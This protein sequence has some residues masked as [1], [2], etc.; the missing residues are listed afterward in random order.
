M[1][2]GIIAL[3]LMCMTAGVVAAPVPAVAPA[4][5]VTFKDWTVGC[6]NGLACQAVA[7][8]SEGLPEGALSIVAKRAEGVNGEFIIEMSGAT[9]ESDR[10]RVVIDGRIVDTGT[11][12]V[13]S[14]TIKVSG[15]D[16]VKLARA[17]AKGKALRLVD[18][19]GNMLG[20]A[21]LFGAAAAFRYADAAQGR[22][23]SRGAIIATGPKI[24]A[25]KKAT[26]PVIA[27]KKIKPTESLPDTAALVALSETSACAAERLGPTEDSAY[28]LGTGPNGAQALVLLNCG[29]AAYNFSVGVYVGQQD[30]NEKW[31]FA[32]AKFDYNNT[33]L[34]EKGDLML[35]VNA[36][37]DSASQSMSS[38]AKGRGIG[39]CGSS[40]SYVW[41]GAMFR[42]T[43][44]TSMEEC[45]GSLDWI[46]VWRADVRLT[47]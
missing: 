15:V 9:T 18:G 5:V 44:A 23:G 13:G 42:L 20:Q 8:M 17:M 7:L 47:D 21:S 40:H 2:R 6:D 41:D 26:L 43:S 32:P 14:E 37:W 31:S 1:R 38:Y 4:K 39:D 19:S 45:R 30:A 22:A 34:T 36:A 27:G 35:L 29:S 10:F 11:L 12:E 16:A 24:P 33:R 28:S 3:A 25:A 46:P